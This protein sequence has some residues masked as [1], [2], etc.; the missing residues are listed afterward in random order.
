MK[1]PITTAE[2]ELLKKLLVQHSE[3]KTRRPP[4][5][6]A[7]RDLS[8]PD[9]AMPLLDRLAKNPSCL[10]IDGKQRELLLILVAVGSDAHQPASH[11]LQR[12][13]PEGKPL[14]AEV[15]D[16]VIRKETKSLVEVVHFGGADN[17]ITE[18]T[19]EVVVCDVY[20]E[21]YS[22]RDDT[23]FFFCGVDDLKWPSRL[24]AEKII[25]GYYPDEIAD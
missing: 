14:G 10:S 1:I 21:L 25:W 12:L 8:A 20:A 7:V 5:L 3:G 16:F 17:C 22:W 24:T 18:T 23:Q 2:C 9:E 15:G 11:I 6:S 4:Y 19:G 13:Q